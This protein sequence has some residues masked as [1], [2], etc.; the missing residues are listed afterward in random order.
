[1]E[2]FVTE[3]S[4]NPNRKEPY[5]KEEA[6][7][8]AEMIETNSPPPYKFIAYGFYPNLDFST[9]NYFENPKQY[10]SL[11]VLQIHF[12]RI[13]RDGRFSLML[14]ASNKFVGIAEDE[15]PMLMIDS[16]WLDTAYKK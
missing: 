8:M 3:F 14:Q 6:L 12:R 13:K 1:M 11:R 9:F 16:Q 2:S 7:K 5:S 4:M 10:A 15:P